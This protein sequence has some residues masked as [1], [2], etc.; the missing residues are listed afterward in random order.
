[1]ATVIMDRSYAQELREKRVA[2]GSDRWDEVWEG[3]Y[4]MAPLPNIE[5]QDLVGAFVD[6]LRN[7]VSR[8]E[9]YVLPGTNVSDR[10]EEWESNYRCPDV[11][12]FLTETSAKNCGTHWR[13]GPNFAV[14]ITSPDD[15]ARDKLPFYGKVGTR[16]L[17]FVD[18]DPWSLEL[19]RL[20]GKKLTPVGSSSLKKK[21]VLP[22]A[23]LP[24]TFRLTAG[25]HRPAIDVVRTTDGRMW[26]V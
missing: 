24:L 3:T 15:M 18:R 7:V 20:R 8:S 14:E 12:V 13:G 22:S 17:L 10:E 16:E 5:H 9:G 1:M 26:T 11:A 4:M 6:V 2:A 25:K 19:L 23:V 21:N